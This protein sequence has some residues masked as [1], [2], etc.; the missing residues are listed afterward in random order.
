LVAKA[1]G[2]GWLGERDL[3]FDVKDYAPVDAAKAEIK[4]L[5]TDM[6]LA[7]AETLKAA[8]QDYLDAT[9]QVRQDYLNKVKGVTD[10]VV[11]DLLKQHKKQEIDRLRSIKQQEIVAAR[12]MAREV[13][14]S[15]QQKLKET[16]NNL[17]T[18]FETRKVLVIQGDLADLIGKGV[19]QSPIELVA[20]LANSLGFKLVEISQE[21]NQETGERVYKLMSGY[22]DLKGNH[23]MKPDEI[24]PALM[25]YYYRKDMVRIIN[26]L[27]NQGLEQEARELVTLDNLDDWLASGDTRLTEFLETLTPQGLHKNNF[28][29]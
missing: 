4:E 13:I 9:K 17:T 25:D 26:R 24:N 23:T 19:V 3:V 14:E 16:R 10:Q 2:L 1:T 27:V 21:R 20:K 7:K 5:R 15:E 18:R 8:Q 12:S 6:R 29:K 28:K 22:Q 11:I